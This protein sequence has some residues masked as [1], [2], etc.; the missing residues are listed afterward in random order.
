MTVLMKKNGTPNDQ[1]IANAEVRK[2][3]P[4]IFFI[5]GA[6]TMSHY[7]SLSLRVIAANFSI[8]ISHNNNYIIL[9]SVSYYTVCN[10]S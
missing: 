8:K 9:F 5:P 4:I 2:C 6:Q 3:L 7:N 10:W 1:I